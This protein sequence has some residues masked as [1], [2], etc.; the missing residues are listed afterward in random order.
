MYNKFVSNFLARIKATIHK[1]PVHCNQ[2]RTCPVIS[3]G[4]AMCLILFGIAL[5]L[6]ASYYNQGNLHE[7]YFLGAI[8]P[9]A[10][11]PNI[12]EDFEGHTPGSKVTDDPNWSAML[13]DGE[14]GVTITY[15]V[16]LRNNSN[17]LFIVDESS[18]GR[19]R[20]LYNCEDSPTI[21]DK[22]NVSFNIF[23]NSSS[24]RNGLVDFV[25]MDGDLPAI[26]ISID[27]NSGTI[28]RRQGSTYYPTTLS[29]SFDIQN[30]IEIETESNTHFR[31]YKD[32]TPS[33]LYN[34]E[35]NFTGPITGV[36][37][38]DNSAV[39]NN[40]IHVYI[41]DI[42][43]SWIPDLNPPSLISGQVDSPTGNQSTFFNFS[44]IYVDPDNAPPSSIHVVI[45]G[46]MYTMEKS[47]PDDY[48]FTDGATYQYITPL[49][50]GS[51]EYFF[52]CS[53]LVYSNSTGTF[54]GP[55][56]NYTNLYAPFVTSPEVTPI[57]GDNT[58]I[59]RFSCSYFDM[60]NNLPAEVN[61]TIKNVTTTIVF[62]MTKINPSDANAMDG[63]QFE[64]NTSLDNGNY[65]F[66][67]NCSDGLNY[68]STQW[69]DGP[70]VATIFGMNVLY[71]KMF[72][73][74]S[75]VVGISGLSSSNAD[76]SVRYTHEYNN[77]FSA[78]Y[79]DNYS[80]SATYSVDNTTRLMS[81]SSITFNN[82]HDMFWIPKNTAINDTIPI[83][84][85]WSMT[86]ETFTVVS[87]ETR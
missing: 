5:F 15:N 3:K 75:G 17:E 82:N 45:N 70:N 65:Q 48:N 6:T 27:V 55:V 54:N 33:P 35:N 20:L 40:N 21:P 32:G 85:P 72:I 56:V 8:S 79:S 86:D 47:V 68:N 38:E 22:Y 37:F 34:N 51:Y 77:I 23:V 59:F 64:F 52:N 19:F 7:S 66:Q 14:N 42:D 58:T 61:L 26:A 28:Y 13:G 31:I 71:D 44:V 4:M 18:T 2:A 46:S 1:Y 12:D 84:N 10:S 36:A 87:I 78:D 60:D 29:L 63:I 73:E 57:G 41:D 9:F 53:N 74:W 39:N 25:L 76:G 11:A 69:I 67:I 30:L 62:N 50:P 80:G 49:A 83:V 43:C 81:S 24:G 16:V